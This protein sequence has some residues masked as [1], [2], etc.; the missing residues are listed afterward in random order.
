[1]LNQYKTNP[2]PVTTP[3]DNIPPISPPPCYAKRAGVRIANKFGDNIELKLGA[4]L[5]A[6]LF[7]K[8][9]SEQK[10]AALDFYQGFSLSDPLS[11]AEIDIQ[12][13]LLP[14]CL[15]KTICVDFLNE[16]SK[17]LDAAHRAQFVGVTAESYLGLEP[18]R[19]LQAKLYKE[20]QE[21]ISAENTEI[22]V[23]NTAP[24]KCHHC[25]G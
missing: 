17:I 21:K 11:Q 7:E 13:N 4:S 20:W 16:Q 19:E 1:M 25:K 5:C 10:K 24:K 8:L 12:N 6:Y 3:I 15:S 9:S 23:A 18:N 14:P 22:T 2:I